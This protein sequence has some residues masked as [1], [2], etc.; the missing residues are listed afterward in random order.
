M[1][2]RDGPCHLQMRITSVRMSARSLF[3]AKTGSRCFTHSNWLWKVLQS[4]ARP[5]FRAPWL[6]LGAARGSTRLTRPRL[7]SNPSGPRA[8]RALLASHA[9]QM[10]A[11]AC[12]AR[13]AP[14]NTRARSELARGVEPACRLSSLPMTTYTWGPR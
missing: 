2:A 7:S 10:G 1:R 14:A 11:P 4:F 3:R 12:G 6:P 13:P 9:C 8:R 5:G